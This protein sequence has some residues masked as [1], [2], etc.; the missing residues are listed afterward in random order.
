MGACG[1][2]ATACILGVLG[3]LPQGA[4]EAAELVILT[5]QGVTPG[6]REVA[7]AFE[8]SSGNKVDLILGLRPPRVVVQGFC[9]RPSCRSPGTRRPGLAPGPSPAPRSRSWSWSWWWLRRAA[10]AFARGGSEREGPAGCTASPSK[11][12]FWHG[13]VASAAANSLKRA[14]QSL[15]FRVVRV[16]SSFSSALPAGSRRISP[17]GPSHRPRVVWSRG[18]QAAA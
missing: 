1:K 8:R 11:S 2:L 9:H 14:V 3:S 18:W 5:N 7:A 13:S 15:A 6:A 17:H 4:A 16:T 12:A 10:A